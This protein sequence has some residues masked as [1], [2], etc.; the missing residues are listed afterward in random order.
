LT[1]G[2]GFVYGL[3]SFGLLFKKIV[4][5]IKNQAVNLQT[6]TIMKWQRVYCFLVVLLLILPAKIFSQQ[7]M[8]R[9]AQNSPHTLNLSPFLLGK[10]NIGV[11]YSTEKKDL[12]HTRFALDKQAAY[13][14]SP[15]ISCKPEVI[16]GG[17]YTSHLPFFCKKELQIEKAT[18]VPLRFRL[19]SLDYV[20]KLEGK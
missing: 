1:E 6:I 17:F 16:G 7:Q 18:Y 5:I 19:G 4:P 12:Q 8:P 13:K 20:N 9:Y 11:G 10:S 2:H 3:F 15:L 14:A